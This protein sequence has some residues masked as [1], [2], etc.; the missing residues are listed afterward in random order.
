MKNDIE[1]N[2]DTLN[3]LPT[4]TTTTPTKRKI[5][6]KKTH[7]D[8]HS[9][10]HTIKK[11]KVDDLIVDENSNNADDIPTKKVVRKKNN[12]KKVEE[13]ILDVFPKI[14]THEDKSIKPIVEKPV[15]VFSIDV[16]ETRDNIEEDTYITT[17]PSTDKQQ[18]AKTILSIDDIIGTYDDNRM[19]TPS[20][21]LSSSPSYSPMHDEK[22]LYILSDF[23]SKMDISYINILVM[24]DNEND[25]K[26]IFLNY[27]SKLGNKR[28]VSSDLKMKVELFSRNK[29]KTL[30]L[31]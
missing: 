9:E 19:D 13:G 3:N 17:M 16:V 20:P 30:C 2:H 4:T 31:C 18:T 7:V 15:V 12:I 10:D 24:A 1:E 27:L 8:N 23:D 28:Y 6:P 5:P 21:L 25:A 14:D 22:K 26:S 29:E 11:M